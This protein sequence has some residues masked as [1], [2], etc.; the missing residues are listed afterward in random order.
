MSAWAMTVAAAILS[1]G[2]FAHSVNLRAL[3]TGVGTALGCLVAGALVLLDP[4]GVWLAL[5]L[6]ALTLVIE[7]VVVRNFA[8]AMVFIT[9]LAVLLVH[10]SGRLP[11]PLTLVW[12]RL[13]ETLIACV[14]AVAVGQIVS[15]R[16]A[17]RQR[18]NAVTA[19]L[20]AAADAV[21]QCT[22]EAVG[23]LQRTRWNLVLVSERTAGERADVR[24]AVAP[25]D[26]AAADLASV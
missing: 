12:T 18:L 5:V 4:H 9:P 13:V 21:E 6:A 8:L 2:S 25:L 19:A 26:Q 7:L 10:A 1:Q 22:P 3:H 15:R 11:N 16:W 23:V 20:T 14:A 17:V 24:A